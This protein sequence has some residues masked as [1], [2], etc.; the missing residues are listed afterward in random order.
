MAGPHTA[1]L[2]VELIEK[3]VKELSCEAFP[4]Y[5]VNMED[6]D[7]TP[8]PNP[9]ALDAAFQCSLAS[10][11]FRAQLLPY[12]FHRITVSTIESLITFRSIVEANPSLLSYALCFQL[13]EK[14]P[15]GRIEVSD[16]DI[17]DAEWLI[18]SSA[19]DPEPLAWVFTAL[20]KAASIREISIIQFWGGDDTNGIE[21][22]IQKH[23]PGPSSLQ[24]AM[25]SLISQPQLRAL[26]LQYVLLPME[27]AEWIVGQ[28]PNA[29][30]Y[31]GAAFIALERERFTSGSEESSDTT[32][33]EPIVKLGIRKR[34]YQLPITVAQ[35]GPHIPYEIRRLPQLKTVS[36]RIRRAMVWKGKRKESE[37]V[38]PLP[39]LEKLVVEA[40]ITVCRPQGFDKGSILA[41]KLR[42]VVLN[43]NHGSRKD[44]TQSEFKF[45]HLCVTGPFENVEIV[46]FIGPGPAEWRMFG[47]LRDEVAGDISVFL[48]TGNQ[49]NS[50]QPCKLRSLKVVFKCTDPFLHVTPDRP[51]LSHIEEDVGWANLDHVLAGPFFG[52]LNKVVVNVARFGIS[53]REALEVEDKIKGL[54]CK[55]QEVH[56]A[57]VKVEF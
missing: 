20:A 32:Q 5:H 18:C 42:T 14:R 50:T 41:P 38:V 16:A 2:P 36:Y 27:T 3:V 13:H 28:Q 35:I 26:H 52:R 11:F 1:T 45:S 44:L 22:R 57:R 53:T 25:R 9:A 49:S 55:A 8:L 19:T 40:P 29:L 21:A 10:H 46:R 56:G 33:W 51:L 15:K 47:D 30:Q 24:T 39:T 12:V 48:S 54:M 43:V 7:I 17:P 31:L 34:L 23:F 6:L 4:S 37:F